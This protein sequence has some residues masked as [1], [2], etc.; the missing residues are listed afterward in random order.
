MVGKRREIDIIP[1]GIALK[2]QYAFDT[3]DFCLGRNIQPGATVVYNHR[4]QRLLTDQLSYS[5]LDTIQAPQN[6]H[7]TLH[8][9]RIPPG[10]GLELVENFVKVRAQVC[11]NMIGITGKPMTGVDSGC[12]PANQ[13][14]IG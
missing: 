10:H 2:D 8:P 7:R 1:G 14:R 12:R 11:Q 3:K 9:R 13:Y 4:F 5:G 6:L